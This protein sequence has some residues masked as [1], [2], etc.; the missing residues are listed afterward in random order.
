MKDVAQTEEA[1]VGF[2][3]LGWPLAAIIFI[4]EIEL[5]IRFAQWMWARLH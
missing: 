1:K 5:V 4:A 2:L 3:I